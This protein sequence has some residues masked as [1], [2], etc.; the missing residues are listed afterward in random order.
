LT[1][2]RLRTLDDLRAE[3]RLWVD[4]LDTE[5]EE[6]I[7]G[8]WRAYLSLGGE[9]AGGGQLLR[10]MERRV[11]TVERDVEVGFFFWGGGAD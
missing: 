10:E 6:T 7:E 11:R 1:H 3:L 2:S 9:V 4:R 5:M 8:D